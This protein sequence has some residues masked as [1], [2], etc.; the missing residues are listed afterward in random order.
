MKPT[1]DGVVRLPSE[2]AITTGSLPSKTATHEFVVP[3]SIP[4]IFPIVFFLSLFSLFFYSFEI[5]SSLAVIF[6]NHRATVPSCHVDDAN[7]DI[8]A[9]GSHSIVSKRDSKTLIPQHFNLTIFISSWA[10]FC[11]PGTY[12]VIFVIVLRDLGVTSFRTIV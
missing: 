4:I 2:L 8:V 12:K 7:S 3:R 10:T 5:L 6:C 11:C 1:I 9:V